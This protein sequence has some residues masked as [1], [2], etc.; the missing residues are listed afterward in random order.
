MRATGVAEA[1]S[2]APVVVRRFVGV[3]Q[4]SLRRVGIAA[5]IDV[6]FVPVMTFGGYIET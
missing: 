4:A 1:C 5:V 2:D 3:Q 6:V